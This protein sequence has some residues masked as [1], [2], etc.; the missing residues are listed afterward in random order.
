MIA[1]ILLI[2]LAIVGVVVMGYLVSLHYSEEEGSFCNLGEGLSC[3]IVN[4]SIY[5]TIFGIPMSVLGLFYFLGVLGV[6]IFR[7]NT[8]TLKILAFL[9]IVFLG[10]SLYLTGIELFVLKNIC[11]F[12]ETS[13]VFILGIIVVSLVALKP[14]KIAAKNVITA[15]VLA[16]LLGGATFVVHKSAVPSG[17]YDTFA[18]C[19]TEKRLYMY[20]SI[21]CSFCAKQRAM[22]GDSFQYVNEIECDPRNPNHEAQRC[23]EKNV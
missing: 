14:E 16:V 15:L 5:S 4:K 17:K 8:S 13:K 23:I 10:P 21:S 1:K 18:Q 9:S 2:V 12:C 11:V 22:F 20:G 6:V 3:D 7:Y 19:L